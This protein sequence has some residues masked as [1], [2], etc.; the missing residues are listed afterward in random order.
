V[1]APRCFRLTFDDG[2]TYECAAFD[3]AEERYRALAGS[4]IAAPRATVSPTSLPQD[5]PIERPRGPGRPSHDDQ[6]AA[7]MRQVRRGR[8]MSISAYARQ[9]LKVLA[10]QCGP[11]DLPANRTVRDYIRKSVGGNV[12]K[13]YGKNS[14]RGRI[15]LRRSKPGR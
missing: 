11:D 13:K 10:H 7:A 2:T 9:V 4:V 8:G 14:G 15:R 1:T 12:G 6:I 5:P 3:T